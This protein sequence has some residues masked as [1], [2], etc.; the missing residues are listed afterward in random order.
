ML[1]VS[2]DIVPVFGVTGVSNDSAVG[3]DGVSLYN[4]EIG[5]NDMVAT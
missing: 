1:V 4:P 5:S 2:Y 3:A